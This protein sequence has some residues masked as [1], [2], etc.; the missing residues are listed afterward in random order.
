M[1]P[2]ESTC[3]RASVIIK[4]RKRKEILNNDLA[5]LP[6][7]DIRIKERDEW[8]KAVRKANSELELSQVLFISIRQR[9]L[10]RVL[11]VLGLSA[12]T[13]SSWSVYSLLMLLTK[14]L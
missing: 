4:K 13:T 12:Y 7:H 10:I 1:L 6:S 2:Y 8:K 9:E 11:A 5:V 14:L 3:S